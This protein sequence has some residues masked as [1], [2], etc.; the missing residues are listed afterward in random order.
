MDDERRRSEE[1]AMLNTPP[2]RTAE[3]EEWQ[4]GLPSSIDTEYYEWLHRDGF[5]VL[6]RMETMRRHSDS[7][8]W[9]VVITPNSTVYRP[10]EFIFRRPASMRE[11]AFVALRCA[12]Q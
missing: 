12:M 1:E 3:W 6:G 8:T 10:D 4:G 2:D 7:N 5:I 9:W 11:V